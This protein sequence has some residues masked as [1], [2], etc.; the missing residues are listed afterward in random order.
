MSIRRKQRAYRSFL[1]FGAGVVVAGASF[2]GSPAQPGSGTAAQAPEIRFPLFVADPRPEALGPDAAPSLPQ[3][4]R[5]MTEESDSVA[6]ADSKT[7]AY[8]DLRQ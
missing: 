5:R 3:P 1:A 2:A 6:A 7:R 4:D 8:P